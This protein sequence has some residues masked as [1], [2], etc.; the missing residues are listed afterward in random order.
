MLCGLM[1]AGAGGQTGS[2]QA[3]SLEEI[4]KDKG[5]LTQEEYAE[6]TKEGQVAYT[7]GKGLTAASAD[8]S[9][10]IRIGGYAQLLYRYTDFD[11]SAVDDKSDFDIRRFKLQIQ[12]NVFSEKLGYKFQGE[13]ASG[14]RTEDALVNYA[15]FPALMLQAGQF[16]PPQ[17]RQ[18]LTSAS[19]QLFPERSLA[20]DTFNL[21]RDQGVLAGGSFAEKLVVYGFGIFNGNG[22]NTGNFDDNHLIAGRIDVNPLGAYEMDEAGWPVDKPLVNIGGSFAWQKIGPGDV[23]GGF[24]PDNDVMD[25]AL[26]LD[27]LDAAEFTARYGSDLTWLLW[28][29]NINATWLGASFAAEYYRLAAE[30]SFGADWDALGYYVQAGYQLFPEKLELAV[31]YSEIESTGA[32]ASARFD[33]SETQFGVNYYFFKHLLKLQTDITLVKDDLADDKDDL[34]Y[35]LQAQLSY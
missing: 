13:M 29:A 21:G 15:F 4:L 1:V 16:E 35:R 20:N 11:D 8:G 24:D 33:K 6:A 9:S 30:P 12:G 7:P 34:I 17:A 22:P 31:R 14:F 25:V 10:K 2:I 18:E 32:N 27:S 28:T 19:R 26:A 23:G 3:R 5:V